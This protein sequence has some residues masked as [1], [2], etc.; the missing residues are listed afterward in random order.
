MAMFKLNESRNMGA[1]SKSFAQGYSSIKNY[2][3]AIESHQPD[4]MKEYKNI[5]AMRGEGG[6]Y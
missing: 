6:A 4:I 5:N 1:N 2:C 3:T